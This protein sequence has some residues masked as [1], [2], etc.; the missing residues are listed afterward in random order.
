MAY[1]IEYG[2]RALI[3]LIVCRETREKL[4]SKDFSSLPEKRQLE[5]INALIDV[6]GIKEQKNGKPDS[7]YVI[8]AFTDKGR[9]IFENPSE[10]LNM[11]DVEQEHISLLRKLDSL[12]RE[13]DVATMPQT[14]IAL[15][16]SCIGLGRY[17]SALMYAVDLQKKAEEMN[18]NYFKGEAAF[19][20][21][22]AENAR[23]EQET[24]LKYYVE[25]VEIFGKV[26]EISREAES[27]RMAG[28]VLFKMGD[29]ERSMMMFE[30]SREKFFETRNMMGVAKAKI[31]LGILCSI[32]RDY[33]TAEKYWLHALE[34]FEILEDKETVAKI[35]TN[36]GA[37]KIDTKKYEDA[38]GYLRRSI[39][40]CREIKNKYSECVAALNFAYANAMLK[41]F[42]VAREAAE[43][44]KDAL[45]EGFD[46]YLLCYNDLVLGMYNTARGPWADAE[47]RFL[48][49]IRFATT[50]G[51]PALLAKCH[52]EYAKALISR[53]ENEKALAEI[54]ASK[55]VLDSIPSKELRKALSNS[56]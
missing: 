25:A 46:A 13:D 20:L 23:G 42:E 21:G 49:A 7:D 5:Y 4:T 54:N 33:E 28:G 2:C 9:K 50:L 18:S 52:E 16:N 22:K 8:Y 44:I 19:L 32:A 11:S 41:N 51:N 24:S 3:T 35:L 38:I 31:N 15:A 10:L 55:S 6:G 17:D 29:Y 14:L 56:S 1:D 48:S 12:R 43:S 36:L 39:L 30:R 53:N 26:G 45:R 40:L 47:K 27:L 37:M 34:F